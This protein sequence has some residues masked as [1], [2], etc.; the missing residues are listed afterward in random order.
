MNDLIATRSKRNDYLELL[1]EAEKIENQTRD[2]TFAVCLGARNVQLA[3]DFPQTFCSF[4][5]LRHV[6]SK[7]ILLN[8]E[9]S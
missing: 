8:L 2:D 3:L 4:I 5:S 9:T 1:R 7:H 6:R